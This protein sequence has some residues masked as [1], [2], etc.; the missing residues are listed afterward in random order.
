MSDNNGEDRVP[1][2]GGAPSGDAG[3]PRPMP[4]EPGGRT[5]LSRRKM[6]AATVGG[7][8]LMGAAGARAQAAEPQPIEAGGK[9]GADVL[10]PRNIPIAR[11][12]PDIL[13]PPRTDRGL[14][15]NVKWPFAL[16]HQRLEPAGWAR[17]TTARE[18]PISKSMAGVNM[19]LTSGG[20]RELH[21]HTASEWAYVLAGRARI[22]AVDQLGRAFIDDVGKGDLWF[23]PPGI[24]HSI[25]G[26]EPEGTEFLLVFDDGDFSEDNT[27][28]ITD[29]FAHTPKAVLA[30]NFGWPESVFDNIPPQELYIFNAPLP[31]PLEQDRVKGAPSVPQSFSFRLLA[32]EPQHRTRGG[33][34]RIADTRNFPVATT[35]AAALVEIEPGGMREM[36]WHPNTDEW[37][38]WIQGQGRMTIF[39][40]GGKARTFDFQAGDVGFVP[41]AMG[42]YIENTGNTPVQFLELFPSATYADVSLA[43]WMALTPHEL[44]AAHLRIDRAL[45]DGLPQQKR[46]VVPA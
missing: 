20:V 2:A 36:H 11:Q 10:G 32:Q 28:L 8:V 14:V 17:E 44:V 41:F 25:Q 27:F 13:A 3:E 18:L 24:P 15:P 30:K 29:W 23:F 45:L 6:L 26:L 21:W 43:Q 4:G 38:Y 12:N 46:P 19:R 39:A 5:S 40:S 9:I 22:T 1:G 35:T 34:V 33:S 16:S 31:G 42:H 7:G 37:Q